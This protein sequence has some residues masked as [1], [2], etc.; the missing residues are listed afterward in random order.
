M[1]KKTPLQLV[2]DQY[3]SKDGLIEKVA[4]LIDRDEGESEDEH[5]KRLKYVSNAKLLHLAAVVEQA[6][7]QGG[8]DG[9]VAKIMELKGQT[10]DHEFGDRLKQ[11]SLARLVDMTRSLERAAKKKKKQA[12]GAA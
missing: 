12:S 10:K 7:A 8:R 3:G 9:L 4:S 1:A 11:L 6:K 5:R 2:K